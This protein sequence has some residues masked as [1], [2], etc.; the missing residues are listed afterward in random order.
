M[1]SA[2]AYLERFKTRAD[3]ARWLYRLATLAPENKKVQ[4]QLDVLNGKA[5]ATPPKAGK[6][7]K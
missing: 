4:H 3:K 2:P 1:V 6:K 7:V 5:P